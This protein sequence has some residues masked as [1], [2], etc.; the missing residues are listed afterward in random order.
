MNSGK[1]IANEVYWVG[2]VDWSIRDF[3][4]FN[5][6]DGSTYN[7]FLLLDEKPA[8]IDG[9][10]AE[11]ADDQLTRVLPLLSGKALQYVICKGLC[12]SA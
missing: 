2:Q 8:L 12:L 5:T 11:Y 7:A 4:S 1:E 6:E 10:K 3:H 9:V